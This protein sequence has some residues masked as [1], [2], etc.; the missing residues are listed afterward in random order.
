MISITRSGWSVYQHSMTM[1][2]IT[3]HR[4]LKRTALL[5]KTMKAKLENEK[6]RENKLLPQEAK[7]YSVEEVEWENPQST[8]SI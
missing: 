8:I 4:I 2:K 5:P 7:S 6:R 3:E 1:R